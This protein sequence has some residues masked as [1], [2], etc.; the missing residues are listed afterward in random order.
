MRAWP[1]SIPWYADK[2]CRHG[3]QY[4]L[5]LSSSYGGEVLIED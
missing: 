4:W 1:S 2:A 5:D 3:E